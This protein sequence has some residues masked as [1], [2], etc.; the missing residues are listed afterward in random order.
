[1]PIVRQKEISSTIKLAVWHIVESTEELMKLI[2]PQDLN[3]F[4]EKVLDKKKQEIL[5]TRIIL[6]ELCHTMGLNY[7]GIFKDEHGKPFLKGHNHHISISHAFPYAAAIIDAN[8]STGIDLEAPREQIHRIKHKFLTDRE[9][10]EESTDKLTI[11]WAGKECLY[12]IYGRKQLI[13]RQHL[14]LNF[15]PDGILW[16]KISRDSYRKEIKMAIEQ[17]NDHWLIYKTV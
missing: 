6:K 10:R 15:G 2:A 9:M 12:K 16:G 3:A 7:Q 1:M 13:F 4:P 11:M 5:A 14:A 8:G 17:I